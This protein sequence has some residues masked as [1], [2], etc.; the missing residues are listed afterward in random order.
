MTKQEAQKVIEEL[1]L[2]K[3]SLRPITT[4]PS[5]PYWINDCTNTA[6]NHVDLAMKIVEAYNE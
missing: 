3:R 6:I 4:S 5:S 2:V 1:R